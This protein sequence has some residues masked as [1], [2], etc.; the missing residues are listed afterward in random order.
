MASWL[1]CFWI[2]FPGPARHFS[3]SYRTNSSGSCGVD[4]PRV[5]DTL[6]QSAAMLSFILTYERLQNETFTSCAMPYLE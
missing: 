5:L 3:V 1:K 4:V 6:T 2:P